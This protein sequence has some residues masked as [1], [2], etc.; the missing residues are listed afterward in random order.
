MGDLSF[1]FAGVWNQSLEQ[2]PEKETKPRANIWASEIGGS[3]IDRY[4]KMHGEKPSNPFS[5]RSLRKFEAGNL[6]EWVVGMVLKRAGIAYEAQ[7]WSSHRY[8]GLLEV[9]GKADYIIEGKPDWE[10][11]RQEVGALG[12]PEFFGRATDA[13]IDYFAQTYP[14][15]IKKVVL[16]V[17]SCSS[18]M[19]DKYQRLGPDPRHKC[20][21]FHY[22]KADNLTEGHIVY[23][24]RDDLRLAE[25]GIY[26][27]SP[28]ED[29]YRDDIEALT[30]YYTRKI[31][32]EKEKEI[33]FDEFSGR[34]SPNFKI[35][36]STY[37]TKLYGYQDQAE[38]DLKFK[39]VVPKW[40]RTLGR[41]VNGDKMTELNLST[42]EE[43]KKTFPD[44]DNI[45]Q[46]LKEKGVKIENS[47]D[48]EDNG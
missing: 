23:F 26:N 37:L 30:Y 10:K 14:D 6:A 45:V 27:P 25:F 48:G 21:I 42:I 34:F 20:Q 1:S 22:L 40:N 3:M 41:C 7:K 5:S 33:I 13:I 36:Y 12:L 47:E 19:F 38:F 2:G 18:M 16:E 24:S 17:K 46:K 35:A 28:V 8:P 43:I 29:E 32:P 9:T 44:F 15:G 4:L 39:A 11:S 31:Q